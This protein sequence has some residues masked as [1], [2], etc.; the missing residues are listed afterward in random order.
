VSARA[1]PVLAILAAAALLAAC[2]GGGD[3]DETGGGALPAGHEG[4]LVIEGWV[5]TLAKGDVEDAAGYFAL[6]SVVQNGGS[7]LTLRSRADAIAFNRTL[8][9]GAKLVRARPLGRFIAA[10]FRLTERPGPGQCGSGTGQIARTAFVIRDGKI[11]QWRRL[12]NPPQ[13]GGGGGGPIV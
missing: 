8:P 13:Q 10:T 2:G 6:P 3:G 7:P 9:C 12:P 4:V 1:R 5:E 11:A